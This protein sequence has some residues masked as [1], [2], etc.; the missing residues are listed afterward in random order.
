MF[1]QTNRFELSFIKLCLIKPNIVFHVVFLCNPLLLGYLSL[2]YMVLIKTLSFLIEISVFYP[3]T[4]Y[5]IKTSFIKTIMIELMTALT[6]VTIVTVGTSGTSGPDGISAI[7]NA[8]QLFFFTK[9]FFR[10]FTF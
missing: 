7:L 9:R 5:F 2:N 1:C 8:K 10:I 6:L 3:S 4:L